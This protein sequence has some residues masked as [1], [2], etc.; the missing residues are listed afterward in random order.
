MVAN[1][2]ARQTAGNGIKTSRYAANERRQPDRRY[3]V[4]VGRAV[5]G[6]VGQANGSAA[7]EG[8]EA[9][10]PVLWLLRGVLW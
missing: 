5:A 4:V 3:V 2:T 6:V 8:A 9:T 7:T 1:S 10:R